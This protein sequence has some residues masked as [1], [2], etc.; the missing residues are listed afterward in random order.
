MI[1]TFRY[2]FIYLLYYSAEKILQQNSSKLW[3]HL[4][5]IFFVNMNSSFLGLLCYLVLDIYIPLAE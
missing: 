1:D 5:K 3:K 4:M 2:V